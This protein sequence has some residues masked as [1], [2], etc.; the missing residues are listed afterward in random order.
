MPA[1]SRI[2]GTLCLTF[3]YSK[4]LQLLFLQFFRLAA[5][6]RPG[7]DGVGMQQIEDFAFFH[8]FGPGAAL[9]LLQPQLLGHVVRV[10]VTS[11]RQVDENVHVLAQR[12]RRAHGPGHRMRAFQRRDDAFDA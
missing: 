9:P 2:F 12:G 8:L 10:L 4:R 7:E 1:A 3:N 6:V 11:P 5:A